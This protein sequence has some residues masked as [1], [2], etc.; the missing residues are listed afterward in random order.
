[1]TIV[2]PQHRVIHAAAAS[3]HVA[4]Q[5]LSLDP[6]V[7]TDQPG[8]GAYTYTVPGRGGPQG[9]HL[10]AGATVAG[11]GWRVY[12]EQP[13]MSVRLQTTRYYALTL[14]LIG[15]ALGG[16]IFGARSFSRAV[17]RPLEDLVTV[18]RNV[19][20]H[21]PIGPAGAGSPLAEI[22]TLI[23]DV[24]TMQR[25][26][27]DS[28]QQLQGALAQREQ[29]NGELQALTTD[30][31]RK[32]RERTA[33]LV[34]ATHLAEEGS[35]AKSEFLANMSHEIR[36]P[37]NGVIGMVELAL[38]TPLDSM[39]REYLQTVRGS[40]DALLVVINDI[41][42]FSKIEAGKLQIDAVDFSVR[43]MLDATLKPMAVRAHEKRLEL[44]IDVAS[45]VP[46]S[47]LGDP[48][49]LRQVLVNLVGNALKF[50][51]AGE[52]L[53]RVT[54]E[55]STPQ[56]ASLHFAVL[57][58]GIGIAPDKQQS[59]FQPFTQADG[60]TTRRYG[61]TGLG[62]SISG[63]LIALMGGRLWV[64]SREGIGSAFQFSLTLPVSTSAVTPRAA[65]PVELAGLAAI[66]VDDNPTNLRIL[67]E[68]L[69]SW[70]MSVTAAHDLAS[71][72]QALDACDQ[73]FS[74]ALVDMHMRGGNGIELAG[75]VRRHPRAST[76][77]IVVLASSDPS[78]E[79]L[80]LQ[81]LRDLQ[82]QCLMKPVSQ[83]PLLETILAALAK[84]TAADAQP[85]A[86]DVLP[87]HAARALRV[88]VAE[89][90]AVNR[91]VAEHLLL[92]RGH[93]AV[94]AVNGRDA[95]DAIAGGRFDLVLM[96]LQMPIM[97]G[98]EATAAIRARE[99]G[100]GA[101]MPIIALTA[102]AMEG[103]RQRCLDADMD[104]YISKPI[105]GAKLF[106]VIDRV[107]AAAT[108]SPVLA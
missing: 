104:G 71:A 4:L 55:S 48:N 45:D 79:G 39:Q 107:I 66:V 97:D 73:G 74:V 40:A 78:A 102:H 77:A 28:Y 108:A 80:P 29:L 3:G 43:A 38:A 37:M 7:S 49:R 75:D 86:P 85:A 106:E 42:D 57:D 90:N 12:V 72:R 64:E 82:A 9:S 60:S 69:T 103:D 62:L 65:G 87:A 105:T 94:M 101:R 93:Q 51:E 91:K 47:V 52:V 83:A 41:L 31:D 68:T 20:M 95:V 88:L 56:S 22:D 13:L 35:R 26:L 96:D 33:E 44:M 53:V 98:F 59:I 58:T 54:C 70:G 10:A 30:L 92:R 36:T 89:D 99:R 11:T 17:T 67:S 15:L 24:S 6:L 50:T 46:D 63:Q 100:S 1:M 14:G 18:V 81:T 27:G 2:D 76:A 25:R 8:S 23:E 21:E 5:D 19:S 34:A 84:R 61:G 16:A 32:V